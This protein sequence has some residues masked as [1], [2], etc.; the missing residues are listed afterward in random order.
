MDFYL[1]FQIVTLGHKVKEK[2]N[3]LQNQEVKSIQRKVWDF[4]E[5]MIWF[6]WM[7]SKKSPLLAVVSESHYLRL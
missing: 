7:N 6:F 5:E 4:A 2:V 3:P 1:D